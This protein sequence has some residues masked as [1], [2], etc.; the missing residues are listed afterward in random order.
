MARY[1]GTVNGPRVPGGVVHLFPVDLRK[2]LVANPT[3]L[4]AWK[5]ITPEHK[6]EPN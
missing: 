3:A 6:P 2:A 1:R 4:G 5:D